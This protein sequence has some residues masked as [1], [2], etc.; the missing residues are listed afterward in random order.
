MTRTEDHPAFTVRQATTLR[1]LHFALRRAQEDLRHAHHVLV[2]FA[3]S[4]RI[5]IPLRPR[6][7]ARRGDGARLACDVT[8]LDEPA[9]G[10]KPST[11]VM[12]GDV[13]A[14]L[15]NHVRAHLVEIRRLKE[16]T[17]R[18]GDEVARLVGQR[19]GH[20]WPCN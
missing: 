10:L 7:S 3:L 19:R 15:R 5:G 14:P 20:S 16:E 2:P 6:P 4:Q 1:E 18:L 11:P 9:N 8:N 17:R 13:L 12:Q